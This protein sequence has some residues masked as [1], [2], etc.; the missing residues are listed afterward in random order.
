M[1]E[2][3]KSLFALIGLNLVLLAIVHAIKDKSSLYL[4]KIRER[5]ALLIQIRNSRGWT[6]ERRENESHVDFLYRLIEKLYKDD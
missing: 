2:I 3:L 1:F 6:Y 4:K 5:R